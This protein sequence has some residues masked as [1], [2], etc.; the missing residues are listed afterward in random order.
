MAISGGSSQ[1][2]LTAAGD[3]VDIP[4]QF[5]VTP[6]E[7]RFDRR[8]VFAGSLPKE[9]QDVARRQRQLKGGEGDCYFYK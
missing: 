5:L 3:T 4:P 9:D 8:F 7:A 2:H 6:L 1:P